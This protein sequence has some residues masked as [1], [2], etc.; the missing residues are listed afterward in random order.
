MVNDG[1][2]ILFSKIFALLNFG[3]TFVPLPNNSRSLNGKLM[4]SFYMINS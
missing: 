1:M 4:V 3:I 2:K